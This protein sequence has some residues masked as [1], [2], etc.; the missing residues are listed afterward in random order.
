[1]PFVVKIPENVII[2]R[3][4]QEKQKETKSKNTSFKYQSRCNRTKFKSDAISKLNF[5]A[6]F[7]ADSE[8]DEI[9]NLPMISKRM[10]PK[11]KKTSLRCLHCPKTYLSQASLG[12]HIQEKHEGK[13][14]LCLYC[15][16]KAKR[17]Y[18]LQH[19]MK[20]H[21]PKK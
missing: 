20:T 3:T 10:K 13:V 19:H 2:R 7:F 5:F 8:S 1:M 17:K 11:K 9:E 4:S 14:F 6:E 21:Q 18:Y 15:D 16:F 12:R